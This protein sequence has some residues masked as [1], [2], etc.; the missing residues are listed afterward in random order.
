MSPLTSESIQRGNVLLYESSGKWYEHL[1]CYATAGPYCHVSIALSS[2]T[3]IEATNR[4]IARNM[5]QSGRDVTAI[6]LTKYTTPER[7]EQALV[8]AEMQAGKRYGWVDILG[9]AIKF[10]APNNKL[11]I[12]EEDR[13]DC[14]DYCTR[15]IQHAGVILPDSFSDPYANTPNDLARV[16]S[17]LPPRKGHAMEVVQL[18]QGGV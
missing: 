7:I 6:D 13:W 15:Y 4:G 1:I 14:S 16:F 18:P 11:R 3:V 17:L 12:G 10:L 9:Q 2:D 5:L 8:W